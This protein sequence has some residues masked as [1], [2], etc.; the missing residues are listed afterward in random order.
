[1]LDLRPYQRAA[2]DSLY[3]YWA[4]KKGDNPLIVAPTGSGKSLIIAHLV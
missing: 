3:N 1:M 2:I 4:S